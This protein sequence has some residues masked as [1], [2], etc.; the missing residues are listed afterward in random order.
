MC[1]FRLDCA[2]VTEH[3]NRD[4]YTAG[5]ADVVDIARD[6]V[7]FVKVVVESVSVEDFVDLWMLL[8]FVFPRC[9]EALLAWGGVR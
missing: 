6:I 3:P 8:D 9:G 5:F 1:G 2:C 4:F 7:D